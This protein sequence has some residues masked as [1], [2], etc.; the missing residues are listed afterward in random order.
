MLEY[1]IGEEHWELRDV[2]VSQ[3][4]LGVTADCK[5]GRI[6]AQGK[7]RGVHTAAEEDSVQAAGGARKLF[8]PLTHCTPR[9]GE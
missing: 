5:P 9:R 6:S 8:S 7:N 1:L 2:H 4:E 3:A